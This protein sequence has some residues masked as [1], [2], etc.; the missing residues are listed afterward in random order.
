VEGLEQKG[1]HAADEHRRV[2]V[3]L[4]DRGTFREPSRPRRAVDAP[5]SRRTLRPCDAG[6]QPLTEPAADLVHHGRRHVLEY[7]GVL[8][9]APGHADPRRP[10]EVLGTQ[11]LAESKARGAC[12]SRHH[13]TSRQ[14]VQSAAAGMA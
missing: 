8:V 6:E 10:R 5:T 7:A 12:Q 14:A 3:H 2:T 11:V 1:A 9:G 4:P 13:A